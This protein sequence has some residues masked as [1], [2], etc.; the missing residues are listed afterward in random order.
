MVSIPIASAAHGQTAPRVALAMFTCVDLDAYPER[1]RIGVAGLRGVGAE[2]Q[3]SHAVTNRDEALVI[4]RS[5]TGVTYRSGAK[6]GP[7]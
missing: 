7:I 5:E 1:V 2:P 6:R 3:A 4:A